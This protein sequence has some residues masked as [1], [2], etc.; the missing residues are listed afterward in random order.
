[1]L[2]YAVQAPFR[3]VVIIAC[4]FFS[5]G[6]LLVMLS[7]KLFLLRYGNFGGPLDVGSYNFSNSLCCRIFLCLV[8]TI[9]F[10]IF[11]SLPFL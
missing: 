9:N 3:L 10:P 4:V 8:P 7:I 1:M 11:R 2:E 6:I 5:V